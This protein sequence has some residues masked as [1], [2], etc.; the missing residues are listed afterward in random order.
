MEK[1]MKRAV[2]LIGV[3][4]VAV[5]IAAAQAQVTKD[6]VSG[7]TNFA[8]VETTVACAGATT[9]AAVAEIKKMG[10]VAIFNL[11]QA[12]EPGADIE[13]ETQAAKDAGIKFY[14][15]PFNG[16]SPDPAV[17]DQFLKA[18]AEKGN[19][20]AF[21]HC[22]SGNRAAAMWL[23]KRVLIDKWD[24]DRAT[25]EADALGKINPALKTFALEYIQKHKG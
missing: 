21:I 20:P 1:S 7:I 16:T 12:S 4:L 2:C 23:I 22:S 17:V 6:T 5:A 9:P 24:I 10:F 19:E 15:L 25:S 13:A 14:H 3:V 8:R 11:R 18:I